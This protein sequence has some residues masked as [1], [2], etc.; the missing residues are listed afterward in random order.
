MGSKDKFWFRDPDD[1]DECDWLFKF[2]TK[3]IA[4]RMRIVAPRVE[5]AWYHT[6]DGNPSRGSAAR[7]F[8]SEYELYH[9]NQIL[10][11]LDPTYDPEQRFGQRMHTVQ[12]IFDS[13]SVFSSDKYA[14]QC[15]V[16][17]AEYL[18][19]DAVIGNVD[20]HHENWGILRKRVEGRWY[21]RLAPTFDHA[22]SLGRELV[23]T[24]TSKSRERYLNELGIDRY[25]EQAHGAVFVGQESRRG[26]SP[27][28]LVRW[29]V[30]QPDYQ[31]LFRAA[32][33]KVDNLTSEAVDE[34]VSKIPSSW[35]TELSGEFV[36][37][38][39]EYNISELGLLS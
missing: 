13:M 15:R 25:A 5:L 3:N 2:P 33:R 34:V 22:S 19:F 39:V 1:P 21:G 38:L 24:G 12:R 9:G 18:I 16:K 6:E 32:L 26:P 14:G 17:L 29:C 10:A 20:R 7:G 23:D 30:H 37:R 35:M 36:V 28:E 11:G 31:E 4:R 8:P 27:L